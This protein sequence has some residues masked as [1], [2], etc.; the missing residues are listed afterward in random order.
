VQGIII[1]Y[2]ALQSHTQ[3]AA[4]WSGIRGPPTVASR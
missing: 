2:R 1:L 4:P 3:W